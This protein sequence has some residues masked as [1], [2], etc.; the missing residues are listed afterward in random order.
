MLVAGALGAFLGVLGYY[1]VEQMVSP[2]EPPL[3]NLLL[4][5]AGFACTLAVSIVIGYKLG[6][7]LSRRRRTRWIATASE[8]HGV[9]PGRVAETMVLVDKLS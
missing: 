3:S 5:L 1:V 2:G 4:K 9:A 8:R 7:L 6:T